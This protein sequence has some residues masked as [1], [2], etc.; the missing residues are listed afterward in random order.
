[1]NALPLLRLLM[2][3]GIS[4]DEKTIDGRNGLHFLP[5]TVDTA[6]IDLLLQAGLSPSTVSDDG[7]TPLH[8]LIR[9]ECNLEQKVADILATQE[10]VQMRDKDGYTVLHCA[11]SFPTGVE[12]VANNAKRLR[13]FRTLIQ[14]GADV[15]ARTSTGQSC[16][17][18][19]TKLVPDE[20]NFDDSQYEAVMQE[21]VDLFSLIVELT[22]DLDTLNG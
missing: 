11:V 9:S 8:A 2:E 19:L 15:H 10:A 22:I 20:N 3:K 12:K 13:S 6:I 14:R 18:L 21:F 7:S 5:E 17:Q 16:L 4:L 1:M